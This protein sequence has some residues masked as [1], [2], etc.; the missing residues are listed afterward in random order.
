MVEKVS[1]TNILYP[2]KDW[3]EIDKPL[4]L[5][6]STF[7]FL[8]LNINRYAAHLAPHVLLGLSTYSSFS[9]LADCVPFTSHLFISNIN[10]T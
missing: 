2:R 3:K 6:F 5:T 10:I 7:V 8:L 1:K 4:L 9:K